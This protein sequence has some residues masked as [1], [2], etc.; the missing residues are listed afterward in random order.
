M[1]SRLVSVKQWLDKDGPDDVSFHRNT[2]IL[3]F[4]SYT[5]TLTW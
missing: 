4:G 1:H 5:D 2:M 3:E